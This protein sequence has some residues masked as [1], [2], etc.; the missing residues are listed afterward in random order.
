MTELEGA[1]MDACNAL[2]EARACDDQERIE[3]LKVHL[4]QMLTRYEDSG[5][6]NHPQPRWA[7][8]HHRALSLS[9]LGD[10]EG[11]IV[12]EEI[13]LDHAGTDRQRE[14]SLGNLAERSIRAGRAEDAVEFFFRAREVAPRSIPIMLTG[15]QALFL[16]GYTVEANRIFHSFLAMPHLMTPGSELTAYLDYETRLQEMRQDL[17]ALD[18]LM[19]RWEGAKAGMEVR[20][21]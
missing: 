17:P 4:D 7:V 15:A 14:I 3:Q 2:H 6:D 10:V 19:T 8:P 11:A 16:A 5:A 12:Y 18:D 13:A 21:G 20:R 9:A 1:I